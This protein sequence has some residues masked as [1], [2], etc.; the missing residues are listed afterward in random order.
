MYLEPYLICIAIEVQSN[1]EFFDDFGVV[2]FVQEVTVGI[3]AFAGVL[4][5][6]GCGPTVLKASL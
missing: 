2:E 1:L 6:K 4:C 5:G 3:I